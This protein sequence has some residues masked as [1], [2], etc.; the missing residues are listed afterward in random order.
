MSRFPLAALVA[1]VLFSS[2]CS[3]TPTTPT[4]TTTETVTD[5][6][7]GTLSRNGAS[8]YAFSVATAGFVYATLTSVADSTTV[9]G[10]SL[11]TWTGTSC[12]VVLSNDQAVQ[13]TTVTG[14]V[15]GL[16]TLC[17]RVYDVGKVASPIDYQVTVV[18]P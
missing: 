16:G 6:F 13:G 3:N 18:H 12:T 5:T 15:T 11:G 4:T 1:A 14:S 17:A 7:S 9:V 2:A 8:S 10:L